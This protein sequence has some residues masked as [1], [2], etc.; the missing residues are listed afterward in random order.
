MT[1]FR[2]VILTLL[3]GALLAGCNTIKGVGR[4]VESV[5]EAADRAI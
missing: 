5:G 4:D 2:A 3:A 1:G